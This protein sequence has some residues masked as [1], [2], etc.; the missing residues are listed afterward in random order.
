MK[1]KRNGFTLIELL[2]VISIIAL[3][4]GILL[5]ALGAARKSAQ[6]ITCLSNL[7]QIGIGTTGYAFANNDTLP[8]AFV[9]T[10]QPGWDID[11]T[12]W[13]VLID[14]FISNSGKTGYDPV[15]AVKT[16]E[17]FLCAA[18]PIEGGR[19]HYSASLLMLPTVFAATDNLP[20]YKTSSAVRTAEV[21]MIADGTLDQQ[22]EDQAT[23]INRAYAGLDQ[24]D[25][26]RATKDTH[27]FSPTFILNDNVIR[28]GNGPPGSDFDYRHPGGEGRVNWIFIDGHAEGRSKGAI[29][30]R[31][32]RADR[33]PGLE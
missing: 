23:G 24:I 10:N 5:P 11:G 15:E 17:A 29:T 3:L 1:V 30:T 33:P 31:M 21:M 4:V 9:A 7:R 12:E 6:N 25:A 26:R 19:L 2:V 13:P 14:S 16:T 28:E 27:Y 8:P 20:L 32:I 22:E 18:A